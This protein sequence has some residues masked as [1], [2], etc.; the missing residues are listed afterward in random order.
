[1]YSFKL[2]EF[3]DSS[4]VLYAILSHRWEEEEVSFQD[5]CNSEVSFPAGFSR[6]QPWEGGSVGKIGNTS[7]PRVRRIVCAFP[8]LSFPAAG[9]VS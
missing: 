7:S 9:I 8:F 6:D 2:K 4:A 3:L 1:M 5:L